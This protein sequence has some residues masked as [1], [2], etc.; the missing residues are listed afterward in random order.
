MLSYFYM[1]AMSMDTYDVCLLL[2]MAMPAFVL[3]PSAFGGLFGLR[4]YCHNTLS[5]GL[6]RNRL[7]DGARKFKSNNIVT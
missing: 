1:L 4:I 2:V 5:C 3:V 7:L 6:P